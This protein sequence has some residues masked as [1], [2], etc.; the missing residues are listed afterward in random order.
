MVLNTNLSF[1]ELIKPKNFLNYKEWFNL[2]IRFKYK[3]TDRYR[4]NNFF[5]KFKKI[6]NRI[7]K[8][9]DP[10]TGKVLYSPTFSQKETI[11]HYFYVGKDF[12]KGVTETVNNLDCKYIIDVGSNIGYFS[13]L[14]ALS[15]TNLE[16]IALEP[17]IYNFSFLA[18][19]ISDLKNVFI[20]HLGLSDV[21]SRYTVSMP[22][23]AN[24]RLGDKKF[25]TGL[26]TA[27]DNK[28]ENGTRFIDG[29][30]F[31]KFLRIN[32]EEIGWIK[33]DVEGFEMNVLNGLYETL[34]KTNSVIEIE[35]NFNFLRLNKIELTNFIE[36]MK[37]YSYIPFKNNMYNIEYIDCKERMTFDIYFIK[38]DYLKLISSRL[39][40]DRINNQ[41]IK[42]WQTKYKEFYYY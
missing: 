42:E 15:D 41:F 22:K 11:K 23:Y 17:D 31:L 26:L 7:Y 35:I 39:Q 36:K 25:V 12:F 40:I 33:I 6:R 3:I 20:Y 19:N 14:Y 4:L 8:I 5:Q 27:I 38:K 13:R 29:D 34:K 32:P 1:Y 28:N 2:I 18:N 30:I 10:I 16:I 24:S 37:N 21:F 9:R